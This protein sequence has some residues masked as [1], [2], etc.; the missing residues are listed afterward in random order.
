VLD[1]NPRE[2]PVKG[3]TVVTL[4]GTNFQN[5]GNIRCLFGDKETKGKYI[6]LIE[7]ECTSPPTDHPGYV[8]LSIA[9]GD[10]DWSKPVKYLYYDIPKIYSIEPPCGPET[11]YTQI[12]VIGANF[13]D[14]GR[15]KALCVFNHTIFTNATVMNENLMYCDSPAI[16]DEMGY[17][18]LH[19]DDLRYHNLQVTIDGG[20]MIAGTPQKFNYYQQAIV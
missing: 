15:N 17:T 12:A 16:L 20:N 6:S 18:V 11:G 13:I 10:D 5:T 7:V 19:G 8:D 3:G 1:I 9:F 14:L 2:G 4:Q